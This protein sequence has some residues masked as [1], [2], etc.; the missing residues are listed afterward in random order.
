MAN[1]SGSVYGLTLLSPI[2]NDER[3]VPSHDLQ[4]RRYL[5]K[6]PTGADS[7]FAVAPGTHLARL[8]V[9]DDVIYVGMP[10]CEEHLKSKYLVF[11]SNCDGDLD[12]YFTGLATKIPQHL[13]A[14][15]SHCTGYP[16]T[17]DLPVFLR[18]M[19]ACQVDTTFFFAAVNDKSV[20]ETLLALQA[21]RAV[22]DFIA[23]HQ[24]MDPAQLQR[25]FID[26]LRVLNA[27]PPPTPGMMTMQRRIK[28]GGHTE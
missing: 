15:W 26:F 18:Y 23:T 16:G 25:E 4:I 27:A 7:P 2:L 5:A 17:Q 9:L 19:K 1:Q 11:E 3:A 22:A 6:L 24:G 20:T 10:S 21:K 8:V 13:D 28:T 12:T 14:I